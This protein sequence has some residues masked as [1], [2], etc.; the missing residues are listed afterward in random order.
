MAKPRS[1]V[2]HVKTEHKKGISLWNLLVGEFGRNE[3]KDLKKKLR[4]FHVAVN[5]LVVQEGEVVVKHGDV[6]H[7][8]DN[9]RTPLP[10]VDDVEVTYIDA[11]LVV[12][13]KPAL[14][15]TMPHAEEKHWGKN[16]QRG[17]QTLLEILT[18]ILMNYA[19]K[20]S[21]KKRHPAKSVGEIIPV[22]RLDRDTSGLM[23]FARSKAVALALTKLFVKHEIQRKYLAV[24]LGHPGD[25]EIRNYL[26]RDRGDGLRGSNQEQDEGELAVTHVTTLQEIGNYSL[27]ECELETGRT[28]QIRIHLAESGYLICG[29]PVYYKK[30]QGGTMKDP[31]DAPR[32]ALHACEL[33]FVHPVTGESCKFYSQL[34]R[35]LAFFLSRLEQG[36]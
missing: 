17:Q 32:L 28:H 8:Y 22:H 21:A 12:V 9:P 6:V 14:L 11:D 25:K 30:R 23:V 18:D 5:G 27:I 7:V 35:D 33:R 2:V 3:E 26:I 16:R 13:N 10:G 4:S 34:P 29:E 15:T 31:S 19:A 20:S 36:K 1:R 24:V